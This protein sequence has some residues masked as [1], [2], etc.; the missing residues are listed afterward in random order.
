MC[1]FFPSFFPHFLPSKVIQKVKS[2]F[3]TVQNC[4]RSRLHLP[5][6][7][8]K[9]KCIYVSCTIS[10]TFLR[11]IHHK[12]IMKDALCILN[13]AKWKRIRWKVFCCRFQRHHLL[14]TTLHFSW[15]PNCHV[16]IKSKID[17]A[18]DSSNCAPPPS[19]IHPDASSF[20][21]I[22]CANHFVF[23]SFSNKFDWS[24]F[25]YDKA[26][27]RMTCTAKHNQLIWHLFFPFFRLNN[28]C[29][30]NVAYV[31]RA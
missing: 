25:S 9:T 3:S 2:T 8:I 31:L 22:L 4:K 30:E 24:N 15:Q 13:S 28:N 10:Q 18:C 12:S 23:S 5:H 19:L 14:V 7:D 26:F 16:N 21:Y 20:A 29:G 11:K 27:I 6:V 1:L 17:R